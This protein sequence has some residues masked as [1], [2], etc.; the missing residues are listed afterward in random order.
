M[1]NL[2][3]IIGVLF[4]GLVYEEVERN[5]IMVMRFNSFRFIGVTVFIIS[6]V[7]NFWLMDRYL[8]ISSSYYKYKELATKVC[9]AVVIDV[10]HE[11]EKKQ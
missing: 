1:S 11:T 4:R 10:K 8:A 9:P 5:G 7:L 2:F 3:K 6:M